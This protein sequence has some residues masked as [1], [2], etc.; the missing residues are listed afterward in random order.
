[1]CLTWAAVALLAHLERSWLYQK[2]ALSGE[3]ALSFRNDLGVINF[4]WHSSPP[5]FHNAEAFGLASDER[6]SL[7][8]TPALE[9]CYCKRDFFSP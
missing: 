1:M 7:G 5:S 8:S 3:C 9:N 4:Q 2:V 6:A